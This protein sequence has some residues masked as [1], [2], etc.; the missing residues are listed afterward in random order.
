MTYYN[1]IKD[2]STQIEKPYDVLYCTR[3][4][5]EALKTRMN[6][7]DIGSYAKLR[8]VMSVRD[9]VGLAFIDTIMEEI[10]R[11]RGDAKTL[12]KDGIKQLLSTDN[13]IASSSDIRHCGWISP[14]AEGYG[15]IAPGDLAEFNQTWKVLV[16]PA[17]GYLDYLLDEISN[18]DDE[19]CA[20]IENIE[21]MNL[22]DEGDPPYEILTYPL[23]VIVVLDEAFIDVFSSKEATRGFYREILRV[24]YSIRSIDFINENDSHSLYRRYLSA[25]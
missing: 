16:N 19:C 1:P 18:N 7:S 6:I 11:F 2:T 5:Y 25:F 17:S 14:K 8:E 9:I 23:G 3:R 21:S 10:V 13:Y 4:M 20:P 24:L 15:E 12:T 22:K